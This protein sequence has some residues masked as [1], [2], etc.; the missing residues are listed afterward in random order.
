MGKHAATAWSSDLQR[1][2]TSAH[3]N[4]YPLAR[5]SRMARRHRHPRN[6]R[7]PAHVCD[8]RGRGIREDRVCEHFRFLGGRRR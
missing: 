1:L 6:L 3:R 5:R 4:R 2:D 7:T 8:F